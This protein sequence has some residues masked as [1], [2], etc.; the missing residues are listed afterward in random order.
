MEVTHEQGTQAFWW[1]LELTAEDARQ[2]A[3]QQGPAEVLSLWVLHQEILAAG[4]LLGYA[5]GLGHA[6]WTWPW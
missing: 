3:L 5:N 4:A 6:L 2:V 1:G